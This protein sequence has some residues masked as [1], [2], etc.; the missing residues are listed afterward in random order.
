MISLKKARLLALL[1]V[2]VALIGCGEEEPTID[3]QIRLQELENQRV[4]ELARIKAEQ[5]VGLAQ[6]KTTVTQPTVVYSEPL[7]QQAPITY[8]EQNVDSG[9]D[10]STVAL[11]LLGG[12]VAGYYASELLDGGWSKGYDDY[13]N[14]IYRDNTNR[15]VSNNQYKK[16]KNTHK[17]QKAES[18]KKQKGRLAKL[19]KKSKLKAQKAGKK[20]KSAGSAA[21]KKAKPVLNKTKVAAKK[22][23]NKAKTKAAPVVGKVKQQAKKVVIKRSTSFKKPAK[24]RK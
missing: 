17:V 11:G 23:F 6:A 19:I 15:V 20:I 14:T 2:P 12:A 16:Y 3:Q 13:G 1:L 21:V 7:P 18:L 9:Y 4:I 22:G 10:G 24:K 5:N 8:S